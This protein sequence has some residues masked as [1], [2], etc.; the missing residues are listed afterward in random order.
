MERLPMKKILEIL[1]LRWALAMSVRKTS[2][3]LRVS[4]G[5]VSNTTVRAEAAGLTWEVAQELDEREL[6]SRVYGAP[7]PPSSGRPEPDPVWIH[8]EY[9]RAGVTLELLHLEYLAEHEGQDPY[10]Y[11]AFCGRYRKWLKARGLSMRQV[12]RAGQKVFVD[13]SGKKPRIF[14]PLTGERE[15]VQLFVAVLGASSFTY[16]EA[17]PDQSLGSWIRAHVHAFGYFE[18]TPATAVPDQLKAA[19]TVPCRYEPTVQ[20][21]YAELGQHYAMAI[22]PA[23]PRKPK[24]KAKAEVGVQV[25]QR[26][27]LARLRN[28]TFF[29]IEA[30]NE[31]IRELLEDMND[32]PMRRYGGLSRRDLF[33]RIERPALRPLPADPFEYAS[34][35]R[36]KVHGDYHVQVDHHYYSVPYSLVGEHVE[37]RLSA[38]TVEAFFRGVRVASHR[39]SHERF[40]HTTAPA[41][42]PADHRAYANEDRGALREWAAGVGPNTAALMVRILE[43]HPNLVNGYRSGL[44][45]RRVGRKYGAER[46][47]S[48]AAVALRWGATSYK[49]VERM[50]RLGREVP[51][52]E[53]DASEPIEHDQ[54]R[55]PDYF[56]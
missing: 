31:R 19:V 29:S 37:I 54:V 51:L 39:R 18:G 25:A 7:A 41:H 1:R 46:T 53:D 44:G 32:R 4:T 36:A 17:T 33:E 55:G 52:Q 8:T 43:R 40:K 27:V 42:M 20:R 9:K 30:L 21:H 35:S 50:L 15:E 45:L 14:D 5:T 49:P 24:D 23:R 38:T 47:E 2:L 16:A 10:G 56:N 11:T 34:W 22:V 26:W 48:A 13:F 6:E 12:H 3:A 28:E